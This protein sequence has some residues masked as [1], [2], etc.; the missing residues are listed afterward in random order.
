[1]SRT[2][3]LLVVFATLLAGCGA[4]S[5]SVAPTDV[6][7][8]AVVKILPTPPG[9]DQSSDVTTVD[10]AQL[11]ATLAGVAKAESARVFEEI[12]FGGGAKRTWSGSDNARFLVVVSRWPDHQTATNVGGGAVQ[13]VAETSGAA[14]W[15]PEQLAGARGARSTAQGTTAVR[16][17][18]LAVGEVSLFVRADGPVTD[19][20]LIRTMD[21]LTRPVR[22]ATR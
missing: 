20:T 10:A 7:P 14:A 6:D 13:E 17:L 21:L 5:L 18:S 11:Q 9:L 19:A 4:D 15:T 12:G 1:M 22:A 3:A 2:I 16:V 8:A